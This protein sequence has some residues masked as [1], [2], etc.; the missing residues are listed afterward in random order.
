ME[1]QLPVSPFGL[2]TQ[3]ACRLKMYHEG[4]CKVTEDLVEQIAFGD[5]YRR[6]AA[7]IKALA[8]MFAWSTLVE[9]VDT[10]HAEKPNELIH[11]D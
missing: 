1:T 7:A 5:G 6:I 2:P 9:D 11:F 4:G 8:D 3:H 10:F